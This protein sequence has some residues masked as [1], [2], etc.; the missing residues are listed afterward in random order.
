[1]VEDFLEA[2]R[3][4]KR[5]FDCCIVDPPRSGL[6]PAARKYLAYV[7]P[8]NILY[9]SCNPST[10]ARD[11]GFLVNTGKYRMT[12]SA[13]FDLYPNTSHLETAVVLKS[14]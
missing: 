14:V 3:I 8:K 7:K 1:M 4:Q 12:H 13:V 2:A 9:I 6:S 5:S 10:Q 11:A